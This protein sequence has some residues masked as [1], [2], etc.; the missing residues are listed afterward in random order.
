MEEFDDL[1]AELNK[2]C[3][4]CLTP[5]D[6]ESRAVFLN[7]NRNRTKEIG[8][9]LYTLGGHQAMLLAWEQVPDRFELSYAWDGVGDWVV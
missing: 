1:V 5:T 4:D 6:D 9:A 2:M 8:Q 7:E 3:D